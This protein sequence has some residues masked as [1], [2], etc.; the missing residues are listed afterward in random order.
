MLD[1]RVSSVAFDSRAAEATLSVSSDMNITLACG[2]RITTTSAVVAVMILYDDPVIAAGLATVL[3]EHGS[4]QIVPTAEPGVLLDGAPP[5]DLVVLADYETALRLAHTARRWVKNMM[6]FTS[7]DSEAKICRAIETGAKGY[8]LH[9]IGLTELFEGIRTVC[10]GG[11]ALSPKV[12]MRIT[13]RIRGGIL[14]AR[15]RSVLEQMMLG[16]SNK[17][18]AHRLNVCV[19][20]VKTHVKSIMAKLGADSRTAAVVMA[21]SRGILL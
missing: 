6:I 13:S 8:L 2:E 17:A 20:T 21:Q 5:A 19:G 9:G 18:I 4:F 14:T 12:A 1:L 10:S 11:V 7:C 3:R 16:L 15:E